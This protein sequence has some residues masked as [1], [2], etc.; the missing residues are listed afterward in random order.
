MRAQKQVSETVACLPAEEN[1]R[2][3][4]DRLKDA[5]GVLLRILS[6]GKVWFRKEQ[7]LFI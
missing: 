3:I 6:V 5:T 4:S 2:Q 1:L 7:P